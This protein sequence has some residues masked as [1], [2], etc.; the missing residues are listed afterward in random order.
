MSKLIILSFLLSIGTLSFS[1]DIIT[2]KEGKIIEGKV[3]EI[4]PPK[5]KYRLKTQPTGPI[6]IIQFSEIR[7][8]KYAD[9]TEEVNKKKT[10]LIV[11][12]NN[13][14]KKSVEMLREF[15]TFS[16]GLSPNFMASTNVYPGGMF[17]LGLEIQPVPIRFLLDVSATVPDAGFNYFTFNLNIQYVFR[18]AE[19]KIELFTELGG[20]IYHLPLFFSGKITTAL[21]NV[22]VG[23]DYRFSNLFSLYFHPKFQIA[24]AIDAVKIFTLNLGVRCRFGSQKKK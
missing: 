12:S 10:E 3:L 4:E 14:L 5:L 7:M 22:G 6:R 9:G 23:L 18:L 2:T 15:R 20:G 21:V 19:G 1:Q 11:S 13:D 17:C 8:I 24:P 16:I